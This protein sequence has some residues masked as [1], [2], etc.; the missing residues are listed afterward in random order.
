MNLH[1]ESKSQQS[2]YKN[3]NYEVRSNPMSIISIETKSRIDV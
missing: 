2:E 1:R 3:L